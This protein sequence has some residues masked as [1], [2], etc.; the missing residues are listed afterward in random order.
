MYADEITPFPPYSHLLVMYFFIGNL[1]CLACAHV[2]D[3]YY[4]VTL[5]TE[6]NPLSLFTGQ[7]EPFYHFYSTSIC[8]Y[9]MPSEWL[10]VCSVNPVGSPQSEIKHG[11]KHHQQYCENS[12]PGI[13][14]YPAP[15]SWLQTC[16]CNLV[17][18]SLLGF[19]YW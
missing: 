14:S 6:A 1:I 2:S 12:S 7:S 10:V 17:T 18:A 8:I 15:P 4:T 9:C 13:Q 3:V 16:T 5:S 19:H 11:Q